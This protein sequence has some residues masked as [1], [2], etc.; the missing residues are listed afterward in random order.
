[1]ITRRQKNSHNFFSFSFKKICKWGGFIFLLIA[2]LM[3]MS[4]LKDVRYFPIKNVKVYGIQHVNR[5]TVQ[6]IVTPLIHQGFFS[7]D[8]NLIKEKLLELPWIAN[9]AVTREWPDRIAITLFEK[10]PVAQWNEKS[11]LSNNGELFTPEDN[12]DFKGLPQFIGPPRQ[13][14]RMLE[15]YNQLN[16]LLQPLHTKISRL[17]LNYSDNWLLTLDNGIKLAV[18]EKDILTRVDHFVKVYPKIVGD[19]ANQVDSIDL[20]YTNGL[21]VKWKNIG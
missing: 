17:E 21:A 19:K 8:V 10:T 1:M 20:R 15:F 5:D 11:L 6:Q 7:V 14:V 4:K 16:T 3:M 18:G 2:L 12:A 9:I 13:Q